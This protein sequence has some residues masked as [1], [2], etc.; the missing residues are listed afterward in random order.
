[1]DFIK[2]TDRTSILNAQGRGRIST[3]KQNRI[4]QEKRSHKESDRANESDIYSVTMKRHNGKE[5]DR[6]SR[7]RLGQHKKE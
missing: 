5:R 2:Q 4:A 7:E 1:M 6:P 3:E